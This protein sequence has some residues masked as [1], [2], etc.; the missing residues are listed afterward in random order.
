MPDIRKVRPV[1]P[2]DAY[3]DNGWRV[4]LYPDPHGYGS[5]HYETDAEFA[6]AF[7]PA[8]MFDA[9]LDA[10]RAE[11]ASHSR[12]AEDVECPLCRAVRAYDAHRP[13]RCPPDVDPA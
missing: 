8:E 6:A 3:P 9:V 13:M 11:S 12:Y 4:E 2:L 1:A 7:A 10:A 5:M